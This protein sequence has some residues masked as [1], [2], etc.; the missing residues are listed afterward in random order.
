VASVV[1][2][3]AARQFLAKIETRKMREENE[4]QL[5]HDV[6]G[7]NAAH[8]RQMAHSKDVEH[9]IY[10]VAATCMQA[11][12]RGWWV[13]DSLTVDHYCATSI[14]TVLRGF[15]CRLHYKTQLYCIL[16]IQAVFRGHV[17]RKILQESAGGLENEHTLDEAAVII[18][19][20]WRGY[21]CEMTFLRIHEDIVSVQKV[22]RGWITRSILRNWLKSHDV[23][24]SS[25]LMGE[26]ESSAN[27]S[28]EIVSPGRSTR[29]VNEARIDMVAKAKE[30]KQ[31]REVNVETLVQEEKHKAPLTVNTLQGGGVVSRAAR[32]E[33]ERR[34]KEKKRLG[35]DQ[36]ASPV[37]I[38]RQGRVRRMAALATKQEEE[39]HK[40]V[41]CSSHQ[42]EE[43][44]KKE[45]TSQATRE[46]EEFR[47]KEMAAQ[48]AF[49]EEELREKEMAAQAALEEKERRKK[50]MVAQAAREEE[51]RRQSKISAQAARDE[52]ERRKMEV[53]A[54]AAGEEE[55]R[56]REMAAQAACEKEECRIREKVAQAAR[57]EE[58]RTELEA[59]RL[60]EHRIQHT[61]V[62]GDSSNRVV[63]AV[64]KR[65]E[66]LQ[67]SPDK[68]Q[69]QEDEDIDRSQQTTNQ[70]MDPDPDENDSEKLPVPRLRPDDVSS[71]Q[72]TSSEKPPVPLPRP[73][74]ASALKITGSD[75]PSAPLDVAS[76]LKSTA[77]D[78]PP[79]SLARQDEACSLKS[80]DIDTSPASLPRPDDVSSLKSTSNQGR[81]QDAVPTP[82]IAEETIQ[83]DANDGAAIVKMKLQNMSASSDEERKKVNPFKIQRNMSA[84]SDEE[85][86]KVNPFKVQ[87]SEEEQRRI[88]K[89]HE[90]F[91]RVG[92]MTRQKGI[93]EHGGNTVA[94]TLGDPLGKQDGDKTASVSGPSACDLIQAWRSRDQTQPKMNG[95]LF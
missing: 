24:T 55:C 60:Q 82:P 13:R 78:M 48:A 12:F 76:P 80:T 86:K 67:Q 65:V 73:D 75:K 74:E 62:Q 21:A 84:S 95:K 46:E 5:L 27:G 61:F 34:R 59:S 45:T 63:V 17:V 79:T 56:M 77:S 42:E 32:T 22:A 15:I 19:T 4:I 89:I 3:T 47:E 6:D 53:V 51:E 43:H 83:V 2:Q 50:E 88:D 71:L 58:R 70:S 81:E 11:V 94:D 39:R 35:E 85:R 36:N 7:R 29:H 16:L 52:E 18:Q 37:E 9:R 10:D 90:T 40:L 49:E 64:P 26:D 28:R 33:L 23:R 30:V 91:H 66:S 69:Q 14:Q 25:R 20:R 38:S 41:I 31:N 1:V 68:T 54:Q 93:K 57:E 44:L 8:R 92:L 87:R 72:S